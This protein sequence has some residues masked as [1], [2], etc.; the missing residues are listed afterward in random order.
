MEVSMDDD[1]GLGLWHAVM[2][3]VA[4]IGIGLAPVIGAAVIV[5][6]VQWV[7]HHI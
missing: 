2:G 1:D 4:L 6:A 7:V 3:V 5:G